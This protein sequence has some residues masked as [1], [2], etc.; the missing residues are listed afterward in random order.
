MDNKLADEQALEKAAKYI[1]AAS[2]GQCPMMIERFHCPAECN[3]ETIPWQC[4][5]AFFKATSGAGA[6]QAT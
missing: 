2:L 3:L 1:C 6:G 4:W 5:I